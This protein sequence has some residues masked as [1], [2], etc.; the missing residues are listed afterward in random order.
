MNKT[1][2]KT[3]TTQ[4]TTTE[5]PAEA[6]PGPE[7]PKAREYTRN[8]EETNLSLM[9]HNPRLF[10]ELSHYFKPELFAEKATEPNFGV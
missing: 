8:I 7:N 6:P 1:T 9:M 3:Q 4:A 10:S 5:E 2:D